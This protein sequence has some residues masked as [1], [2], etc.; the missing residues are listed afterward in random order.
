M[1]KFLENNLGKPI[2][3]P[4]VGPDAAADLD[5]RWSW[6][7]TTLEVKGDSWQHASKDVVI[8]GLGWVSVELSN[9]WFREACVYVCFTARSPST[10]WPR[11][12]FRCLLF[13]FR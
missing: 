13:I 4:P 1:E 10:D 8:A 12:H 6:Q 5:D 7:T 2:L 9:V 11:R 3:H